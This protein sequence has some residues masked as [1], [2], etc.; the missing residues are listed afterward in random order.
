MYD[1]LCMYIYYPH[2]KLLLFLPIF[3]FSYLCSC[4]W[5]DSSQTSSSSPSS[6]QSNEA[7]AEQCG[8]WPCFL[9]RSTSKLCYFHATYLI[10]PGLYFKECQWYYADRMMQTQSKQKQSHVSAFRAVFRTCKQSR[11]SLHNCNQNSTQQDWSEWRNHPHNSLGWE[12][13]VNR[14][15]VV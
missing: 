7:F 10:S 11:N 1:T 12:K 5:D 15:S 4:I 14:P 9:S 2:P 8:C 13:S 3:N 6:I